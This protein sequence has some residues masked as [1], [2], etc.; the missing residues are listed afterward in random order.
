MTESIS[1]TAD[2][3]TVYELELERV[4][5]NGAEV[6]LRFVDPIR[7]LAWIVPLQVVRVERV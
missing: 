3:D 7:R 2:D 5:D 1:L 6:V 4:N